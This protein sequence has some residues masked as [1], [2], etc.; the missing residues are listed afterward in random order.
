MP[1]KAWYQADIR[2]SVIA[3]L[4][5]V[6]RTAIAN[7]DGNQDFVD[8]AMSMAEH[9]ANVFG[10]DGHGLV[11]EARKKVRLLEGGNER[12]QPDH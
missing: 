12:H 6:L 8:G 2:A 7:G 1:F 9:Q 11:V 4:V 5:L 3:G 10:L